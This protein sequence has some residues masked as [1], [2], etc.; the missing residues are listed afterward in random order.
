MQVSTQ[1]K[2]TMSS[3]SAMGKSQRPSLKPEDEQGSNQLTT[4]SIAFFY[5]WNEEMKFKPKLRICECEWTCFKNF[6]GISL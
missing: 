6:A 3:W 1:N 4:T 5:E 2:R